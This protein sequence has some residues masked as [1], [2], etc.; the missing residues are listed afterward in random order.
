[1]V[2]PVFNVLFIH[3]A[4]FTVHLVVPTANQIRPIIVKHPE[5]N[6]NINSIIHPSFVI[7]AKPLN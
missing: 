6:P 7:V 1:V 3:T 5:K 2:I 4:F